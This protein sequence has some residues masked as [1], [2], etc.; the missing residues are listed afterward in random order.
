MESL[1]SGN[2]FELTDF[3]KIPELHVPPLS[4]IWNW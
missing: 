4:E 3:V 2:T 1:N